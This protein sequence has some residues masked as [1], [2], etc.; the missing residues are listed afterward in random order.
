MFAIDSLDFPTQYDHSNEKP[1]TC[2]NERKVRSILLLGGLRA[3]CKSQILSAAWVAMLLVGCAGHRQDIALTPLPLSEPLAPPQEPLAFTSSHTLMYHD[4]SLSLRT[5][6]DPE[7][8][9][10]V[11]SIARDGTTTI[12]LDSGEKLAA[13]PGEFF[14]CRQ[15]GTSG[16][17]LVSASGDTG[18]AV[19]RRTTCESR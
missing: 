11:V 8:K 17:Q 9:M 13:K 15:F 14:P 16:L 5:P 12:Q 10:C 7:L 3:M 18:A 1:V 4:V 6:R 19:F 2:N